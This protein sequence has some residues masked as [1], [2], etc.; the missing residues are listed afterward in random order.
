MYG[1]LC[2]CLPVACLLAGRLACLLA[3]LLLIA[4]GFSWLLLVAWLIGWYVGFV[5]F[6]CLV[7]W[8]VGWLFFI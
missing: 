6:V 8:F 5:C 3:W 1:K 2:S 7:G 4:L